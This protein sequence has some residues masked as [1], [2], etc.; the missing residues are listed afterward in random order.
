VHPRNNPTAE[1]IARFHELHARYEREAG[2][3]ERAVAAEDRKRRAR[4]LGEAASRRRRPSIF[5]G[6]LQPVGDEA[7]AAG[8]PI[9]DAESTASQPRHADPA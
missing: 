5:T 4:M 8:R 6:S 7:D 1:D 3:E 9:H 2:R